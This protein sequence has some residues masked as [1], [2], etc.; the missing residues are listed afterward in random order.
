MSASIVPTST[1]WRRWW[2]TLRRVGTVAFFVIV[3]A[4]LWSQARQIEWAAVG[5]AMRAYPVTTLLAAA[6]LA[7]LSHALYSGIDLFGRH[8]TRHRLPLRQVM[9][10][11]FVCYAFNLNL[12][13]LVGG[14]AMRYRLYSRLGLPLDT[15]T[16]VVGMS[17][18]TNWLGYLAL[19]GAVFATRTITPPEGWKIG[20]VALQGLG[21]ALLATAAAYVLACAFSPG[22][23]LSLRGHEF[24]L[25]SGRIAILQL[26]M[27]AANWATI[28]GVVYVLLQGRVDYPLV[29]GTLLVAAV[30]GVLT[31]IPAGLGVLEAVFIAL[32]G[33]Q[34]PRPE[35]LGALL[36][37][38]ALYYLLPLLLATVMYLL[39]EARQ[40]ASPPA[41]LQSRH[42]RR[43]QSLR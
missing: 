39:M 27:S 10:L 11:T 30:A 20:A 7:A 5:A 2:P 29:L 25:P 35:L 24:T 1:G 9:P 17:L 19:A 37:Y 33:T 38:R 28:G 31:H 22:R 18:A 21:V 13:S 26:V 14:L 36:T 6:A 32:L 42:Q 43:H 15:I 41:R 3:A 40:R 34:V 8:W 12:G 23:S 4:L 16:R